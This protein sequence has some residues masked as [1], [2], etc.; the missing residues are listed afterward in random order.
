MRILSAIVEATADLVPIG[1]ADL[2]HRRGIGPNISPSVT[3]LRGEPY[4]FMI[5][6]RSLS[7]AALSRFDVTTASKTSPS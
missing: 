4:F 1:G 3:T 6:L 2:I 5:R 7:A